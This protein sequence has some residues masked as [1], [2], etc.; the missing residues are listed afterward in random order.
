MSWW[1]D[2]SVVNWFVNA[3]VVVT[4]AI[5]AIVSFALLIPLD[6]IQ[7]ISGVTII[8]SVS[9]ALSVIAWVTV[10]YYYSQPD[11]A[12]NLVWL[13]THV[14]FLVMFPATIAATAMNVTAVQNTRN[15]LAGKIAA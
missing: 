3:F 6:S 12:Q 5:V 15:L 7:A 9:Y 11:H 4:G 10:M 2:P 14:V 13:L 1:K 8:L